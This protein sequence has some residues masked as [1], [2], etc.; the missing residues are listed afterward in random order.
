MA[1]EQ[2]ISNAQADATLN[3]LVTGKVI[4]SPDYDHLCQTYLIG[5][6]VEEAHNTEQ[7]IS[8]SEIKILQAVAKSPMLQATD[9]IK[10]AHISPNTFSK[11]RGKLLEQNYIKEHIVSG[12]RG[13]PA[14]VW[15]LTEKAFEIIN[16]SSE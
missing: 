9:Y 11:I 10:L 4:K 13:R 2:I 6:F 14:K 16:E 3:S 15:E 8:D 1:M 7:K 5:N 12:T